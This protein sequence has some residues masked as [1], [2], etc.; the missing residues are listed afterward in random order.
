MLK[1]FKYPTLNIEYI[2][3]DETKKI[4]SNETKTN[5]QSELKSHIC[6][7]CKLEMYA[8]FDEFYLICPQCRVVS[9]PATFGCSNLSKYSSN[10]VSKTSHTSFRPIISGK[11]QRNTGLAKTMFTCT[12]DTHQAKINNAIKA[13]NKF[14]D[15]SSDLKIPKIVLN[16][17]AEMFIKIIESDV[18]YTRRGMTREGVMCQLVYLKCMEHNCTKSVTQLAKMRQIDE[19]RITAGMVD[20]IQFREMGIID[21]KDNQD[22]TLSYINGCFETFKIDIRG[23]KKNKKKFCIDCVR[24]IYKKKIKNLVSCDT[25]TICVGVVYTMCKCYGH[26]LEHSVINRYTSITEPTYRRVY[27]EILKHKKE[28]NKVFVQN[29]IPK[30]EKWILK[31]R[32]ST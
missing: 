17:A 7:K 13:F 18:E 11:F 6:K 12:G 16:D 32:A 26:T 20:L 21:F 19:N 31:N 24:R 29:R 14:N 23:E 9:K 2:P 25:K 4:I 28:L 30:P 15:L 3:I 5:N 27:N 8:E 1:N 22:P 10:N